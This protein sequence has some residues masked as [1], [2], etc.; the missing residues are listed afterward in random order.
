MAT[1]KKQFNIMGHKLVPTHTII[2]EK[3]HK[4]VLKKYNIK[5]DQLPKILD[6]DPASIFIGAKPGQIVKIVRKSQIAKEAFAYRLVVES[7]K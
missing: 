5:H 1:E 2:S 6:T 4:E 7:N 3:E